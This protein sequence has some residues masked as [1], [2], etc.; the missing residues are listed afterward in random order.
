MSMALGAVDI[1]PIQTETL[2]I[3]LPTALRLAETKP[4]EIR[5]AQHRVAAANAERQ[6]AGAALLPD[7]GLSVGR[8]RLRGNITTVADIPAARLT[9]F[10]NPV[11]VHQESLAARLNA[12][13]AA[14]RLAGVSQDT[15]LKVADGYLNLVRAQ[16]EVAVAAQGEREMEELVR[17]TERL[18]E[19]GMAIPADRSRTRVQLAAQQQETV[20]AQ[21]RFREASVRLAATLNLDLTVTLVPAD[22]ELRQTTLVDQN[23]PLEQ[24][25][26]RAL[27][28]RPE[29]READS[30]LA[31]RAARRRATASKYSVPRVGFEKWIGRFDAARASAGDLRDHW[32]FIEWRGLEGLGFAAKGDIR[33]A[34]ER[35]QEAAAAREQTR[36]QVIASVLTAREGALAAGE[37][38]KLAGQAIQDA[39]E[40]LR[41][42]KLRL[43]NQVGLALEVLQA[44]TALAQARANL[45]TAIA[46]YNLA[47]ARLLHATGS[48]SP[49]SLRAGQ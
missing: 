8:G 17:L 31:E 47:Q 29:I 38:L 18:Q 36:A 13:V 7:L 34:R 14:A 22:N 48:L 15:Y 39:H 41:I 19:R 27:T 32:W 37:R 3:D 11:V 20:E 4:F 46:D 28:R 45:L 26:Q 2:A 35:E 16:A 5:L 25:I 44:Q 10:V 21:S 24:L 9:W 42:S 49:Q 33:A 30:S 43:E 1:R 6:A 40:T 12:V 23:Q